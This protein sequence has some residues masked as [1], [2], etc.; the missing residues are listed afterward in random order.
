[1]A[2]PNIN[3]DLNNTQKFNLRLSSAQPL[4]VN[5]A[6]GQVMPGTRNYELLT[7]KP[8]INGVELSGDQSN[9][10]LGIVSENTNDGW[11]SNPTYVPKKGELVIYTDTANIKIGD[12]SAYLVDIP[13]VGSE[14]TEAIIEELREHMADDISHVTQ[15]DRD[16]WNAKLNYSLSDENLV[17]TRS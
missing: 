15:A 10:N 8:C 12:G 13:F 16:F 17:L 2:T 4:N 6:S 3:I 1:M 14:E 7:N 9:I 5:M 11:A